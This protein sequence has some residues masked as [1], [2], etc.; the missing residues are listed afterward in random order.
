MANA[1]MRSLFENLGRCGLEGKIE[2]FFMNTW[3]KEISY[4]WAWNTCKTQE[5]IGDA[6]LASASLV[7]GEAGLILL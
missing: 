7:H 6:R 4:K 2:I 3:V 5:P 1:Q